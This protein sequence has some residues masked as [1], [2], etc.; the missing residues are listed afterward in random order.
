[1]TT[2]TEKQAVNA[3][4]TSLGELRGLAAGLCLDAGILV[5]ASGDQGWHYNHERRAIVVP[6]GDIQSKGAAYCAG[7]LAHEVGHFFISRYHDMSH[8]IEFPSA[9]ILNHLLNATEDPRVNRW[10]KARYPGTRRWF[11]ALREDFRE[12]PRDLPDILAFGIES[13]AEEMLDWKPRPPGSLPARVERALGATREARI[14]MSECLPSRLP[15]SVHLHGRLASQVDEVLRTMPAAHAAGADAG[16]LE[17]LMFQGRALALFRDGVAP[18]L[19][20]LLESDL[21]RLG[22]HLMGRGLLH[23]VRRLTTNAKGLV[24]EV[25]RAMA[26]VKEPPTTW[27]PEPRDREGLMRLLEF[28]IN[29]Q[30]PGAMGSSTG[31]CQSPGPGP[32]RRAGAAP[33]KAGITRVAPM[34]APEGQSRGNP[35]RLAVEGVDRLERLVREGLNPM[36]HRRHHGSY[37]SG[38]RLSMREALRLD[39]EPERY[40]RLWQRPVRPTRP[41]AA[42][43]LL[44]DLSGSMA[45]T[46]IEAAVKGTLL[47]AETLGRLQVPCLIH[48]FQ[49][50]LV[51]IAGW[52]DGFD[53]GIRDRIGAMALEVENR[54]PGGNNNA[55][56][57][58]DGPCLQEFAALVGAHPARQKF[59]AVVSD[60]EPAGARSSPADLV[61]AVAK[62][63]GRGDIH[64]IGLGLG[65]GTGHVARYYPVA[66]A[67]VPEKDFPVRIGGLILRACGVA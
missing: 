1:M 42:F 53:G 32:R 59:L 47:L 56:N 50:R 27:V 34:G 10:I 5:E 2:A 13:H 54:R 15:G 38:S 21:L 24:P 9:G 35:C 36:R 57:N 41:D 48:G 33:G 40:R 29:G 30:F 4:T 28:F 46:K 62:V 64:L 6:D 44:V 52:Q 43:G 23:R 60:G 26:E 18:C 63:T 20:A 16:E 14:A 55:G 12:P 11:E 58:D 22:W 8:G 39:A 66:I 37:A 31:S 67:D 61:R 25:R 3:P 19:P 51:P 45:G 17:V 65:Q 7:V 49:D